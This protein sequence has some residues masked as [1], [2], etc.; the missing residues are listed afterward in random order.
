MI[1]TFLLLWYISMTKAT[2]KEFNWAT[3]LEG[4]EWL[5]AE[6]WQDGEGCIAFERSPLGSQT[7]SRE[8][9]GNGVGFGNL[10]AVPRDL[11]S[12]KKFHQLRTKYSNIWIYRFILLQTAV[13][14]NLIPHRNH[15]SLPHLPPSY[16]PLFF[17]HPIS[18]LL[19]CCFYICIV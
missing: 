12:P 8:H 7:G 15:V 10:K 13:Q 19:H 16:I 11:L 9:V 6:W 17:T 2:S 1:V 14:V 5:I 3:A 18:S 4:L